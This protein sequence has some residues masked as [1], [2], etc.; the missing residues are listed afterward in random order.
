MHTWSSTELATFPRAPRETQV[1]TDRPPTIS[2]DTETV[3]ALRRQSQQ[4]PDDAAEGDSEAATLSLLEPA[5][6]IDPPTCRLH[7]GCSAS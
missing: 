3:A 4:Q 7:G 1:K 5:G 6:G 2:P